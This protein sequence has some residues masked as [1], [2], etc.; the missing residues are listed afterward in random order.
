MANYELKLKYCKNISNPSRSGESSLDISDGAVKIQAAAW[1]HDGKLFA[2][3]NAAK[4]LFIYDAEDLSSHKEV[5]TLKA[6]EK[7]TLFGNQSFVVKGI[8]FHPSGTKI[9]IAQSDDV[10]FMYKFQS[11]PGVWDGKKSISNKFLFESTPTCIYW[12]RLELGQ[13]FDKCFFVGNLQ[14]EVRKCKTNSKKTQGDFLVPQKVVPAYQAFVCAL[15]PNPENGGFVASYADGLIIIWAES[16]GQYVKMGSMKHSVAAYALATTVSAIVAAGAD[17]R[18]AVYRRTGGGMSS[19]VAGELMQSFDFNSDKSEKEFTCACSSAIS[20]TVAVASYDRVRTFNWNATSEKFVELSLMEIKN[21]YTITV[22]QWR[23]DGTN[24]LL[25]TQTGLVEML[26]VSSPKSVV[27]GVFEIQYFGPKQVLV[28]NTKKNTRCVLR[29]QYNYPITKVNVCGGKSSDVSLATGSSGGLTSDKRN[30]Y[31]VA[32]TSDTLLIADFLDGR[33]SE[34]QWTSGGNEKFYFE[35]EKV[36]VI[37][38]AGEMSLVE[39][40][41]NEFLGTVRTEFTNPH[42][43]SVR[44]NERTVTGVDS[45]DNKKLAYLVDLKTVEIVDLM[46]EMP[47][48]RCQ[49]QS[50]IKWLELNETG[51]KLLFRDVKY[52]LYLVDMATE[53]KVTMLDLCQFVQW[54]PQSDVIVAQNR[55]FLCVWYNID[56]PDKVSMFP[57]KGEVREV[58]RELVREQDGRERV[59]TRVLVD[60][61]LDMAEYLLDSDLIAFGAAVESGQLT[62]AMNYLENLDATPE[63]AA[64]WR[65]LASL[66]LDQLRI[67]IAQ[68]C[69]AELGDIAKARYLKK[70]VDLAHSRGLN[71]YEPEDPS[72]DHDTKMGLMWRNLAEREPEIR[73]KILMLKKDFFMAQNTFLENDM[74]D[75]AIEMFVKI[76]KWEQALQLASDRNHPQLDKLR[77]DCK[78]WLKNHHQQ[79][80]IAALYESE[81]QY[82]SAIFEYVKAGMPSKAANQMMKRQE[83]VSNS[84][85]L[86]TVIKELCEREFFIK[87]GELYEK[88]GVNDRALKLYR[89]A[90]DKEGF[91]NAVR[92]AREHDLGVDARDLLEEYADYLYD[93]LEFE[94]AMEKYLQASQLIK[95]LK[96][97]FKANSIVRAEDIFETIKD[98]PGGK[99]SFD[100]ASGRGG[101]KD[102][103]D[104]LSYNGWAI[105]LGQYYASLMSGN[106][107]R[108][109]KKAQKYFLEGNS[110]EHIIDMY[111]E[112]GYWEKAYE[113]L[114]EIGAKQEATEFLHQQAH[115]CIA[116]KRYSDAE[117]VYMKGKMFDAIVDMYKSVEDFDNVLRVQRRLGMGDDTSMLLEH[118][119]RRKRDGDFVEAEKLY[120]EAGS[121]KEAVNMYM[122]QSKWEDARRVCQEV[123]TDEAHSKEGFIGYCWAKDMPSVVNAAKLLLNLNLLDKVVE[124]CCN[125]IAS[126]AAKQEGLKVPDFDM[127]FELCSAAE[128]SDLTSRVH[129]LKGQ[130]LE[131]QGQ[132]QLAENEF[133]AANKPN[134]A[135]L[136]YIHEGMLDAAQKVADAH[137][138]V[139]EKNQVYTALGNKKFE[140]GD[141]DSAEKLFLKSENVEHLVSLYLDVNRLDKV[142]DLAD[143]GY[144]SPE[145]LNNLSAMRRR[146]PIGV[147][148]SGGAGASMGMGAGGD[149]SSM[150]G[151]S[152]IV[153]ANRLASNTSSP[154]DMREGLKLLFSITSYD[155]TATATASVDEQLLHYNQQAMK[156]I[157]TLCVQNGGRFVENLALKEGVARD[158]NGQNYNGPLLSEV[159]STVLS[160]QTSLHGDWKKGVSLCLNLYN[161]LSKVS[162]V[163]EGDRY[164][165]YAVKFACVHQQFSA[166]QK[167]VDHAYE[168][169][170][171]VALQLFALIKQQAVAAS[172]QEGDMEGLV[173]MGEGFD[174]LKQTGDYAKYLDLVHKKDRENG[175][176]NMPGALRK[177]IRSLLD[178]VEEGGES[179][180]N[181]NMSK[182]FSVIED[183]GPLADNNSPD[184]RNVYK[185]IMEKLTSAPMP[186]C[187]VLSV[188]PEDYRPAQLRNEWTVEYGHFDKLRKILL[189]EVDSNA[190]SGEMLNLL[191]THFVIAHLSANRAACMT[192]SKLFPLAA[193]ITMALTM[194]IH[195]VPADKVFLEAGLVTRLASMSTSEDIPEERKAYL[196]KMAFLFINT[197]IDTVEQAMEGET[198]F[199]SEYLGDLE[200]IRE[201]GEILVPKNAN[202][203]VLK[204]EAVFEALKDWVLTVSMD[205]SID[206]SSD[207]NIANNAASTSHGAPQVFEACAGRDDKICCI[208]GYPI[209]KGGGGGADIRSVG[210]FSFSL[211]NSDRGLLQTAKMVG[212]MGNDSVEDRET[213]K[214]L[215]NDDF[216]F[217]VKKMG[218]NS[219]F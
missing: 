184:V 43:F 172:R 36:C 64:H 30:R 117:R 53:A 202:Q 216:E 207:M 190:Y 198:D 68:R 97:A 160:R 5:F 9:A 105:K 174:D 211:N 87:A 21:L 169:D 150:S 195:E 67:P 94:M 194:F 171:P 213:I 135:L 42:Q 26:E 19:S 76:G 45:H 130:F 218:V 119:E 49:H 92:L 23:P 4:R 77:A 15:A 125:A 145:Q 178:Q 81:G 17:M 74:L 62:A 116:E 32:Y 118:A 148:A 107:E 162:Q 143:R 10:V 13:E 115:T 33:M 186:G 46:N 199:S 90:K 70:I 155:V 200:P 60:E 104:E 217:L 99:E 204:D 121:W 175:T 182:L 52:K 7:N 34:V 212:G 63:T 41:N 47:T 44:I 102:G 22:L 131:D 164:V 25:G 61:K 132:F 82:E 209:R 48:V 124:V 134:E 57:I 156:L 96:S 18:I 59:Q 56:S 208:T 6:R 55:D 151:A 203:C 215:T 168:D 35:I 128:R 140:K 72:L 165:E 1:S 206:F 108:N 153:E 170:H 20:E 78:E 149:A 210:S 112:A 95:A 84:S 114:M 50:K 133:I 120:M 106:R 205:N 98:S 214:K 197:F 109:M 31:L 185:A 65:T 159:V 179:K 28:R 146:D 71:Q 88:A 38:N 177:C 111:K 152:K 219:Q 91:S 24:I 193:K 11:A 37:F 14:G 181:A 142:H 16:N 2:F 192:A 122:Q 40:G 123:G 110:V 89:M 139:E 147:G 161:A 183:Y 103:E 188:Q 154:H 58:L 167:I 85:L 129:L 69:Y 83:L 138:T 136:M 80:K 189:K 201:R 8:A 176:N 187:E 141:Y 29:S 163:E 12:P 101:G 166:A 191:S 196:R 73:A 75:S 54:V 100:R 66:S 158:S 144:L 27:N 86:D 93:Q 39:Y 3:V 51:R 126:E 137:C 79:E 127:A 180:R 173:A 113:Y 157:E